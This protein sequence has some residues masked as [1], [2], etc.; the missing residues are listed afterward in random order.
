MGRI[1]VVDDDEDIRDVITDTLE[2]RH[3]IEEAENGEVG[4]EKIQTTAYDLVILDIMMPGLNGFEVLERMRSVPDLRTTKVLVLSARAEV[5]DQIRGLEAG[6]IDYMVK[7]S[8]RS[9]VLTVKVDRLLSL[10]FAEEVG[11]VIEGNSRNL[12]RELEHMGVLRSGICATLVGI[13]DEG[14]EPGAATAQATCIHL[15]DEQHARLHRLAARSVLL[16]QLLE[17]RTGAMSRLCL[18]QLVSDQV[19]RLRDAADQNLG[20]RLEIVIPDSLPENLPVRGDKVL[21]DQAVWELLANALEATVSPDDVIRVALGTANGHATFSVA[22][23]GVGLA[24][25]ILDQVTEPFIGLTGSGGAPGLGLPIVRLIAE[26]HGGR[27]LLGAD[28]DLKGLR[29]GLHLPM[30]AA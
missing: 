17:G 23:T 18:R 9:D 24:E 26:R 22:D 10:R 30:H 21:L 12:V 14:L 8:F 29:V 13:A 3:Q 1:L 19:S 5:A 27:L 11:R 4:L 6:A 20:R 15:L 28:P 16:A 2:E 7:S 25:D